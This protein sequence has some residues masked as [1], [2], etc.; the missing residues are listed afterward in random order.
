MNMPEPSLR[1]IVHSRHDA[2]D[3]ELDELYRCVMNAG[4]DGGWS[5]ESL[6]DSQTTLSTYLTLT[7][8]NPIDRRR[9]ERIH[10]RISDHPCSPLNAQPQGPSIVGYNRRSWMPVWVEHYDIICPSGET[11]GDETDIDHLIVRLRAGKLSRRREPSKEGG[12]R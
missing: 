11:R 9:I 3:R 4:A 12:A 5:I 1:D 7:R 8:R 6:Y 10:I 2:I